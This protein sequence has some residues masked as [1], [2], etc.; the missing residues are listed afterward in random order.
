MIRPS[1]GRRNG[2]AI[3]A[4]SAEEVVSDSPMPRWYCDS[5]KTDEQRKTIEIGHCTRD[6]LH[7][8]LSPR[9]TVWMAPPF[10]PSANSSFESD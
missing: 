3:T 1:S 5:E 8:R 9:R 4:V 10:L 6:D 2:R 7:M